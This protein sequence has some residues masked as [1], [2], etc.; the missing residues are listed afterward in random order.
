VAHPW[1]FA[2]DRGAWSEIFAD[3][4]II[5]PFP[6]LARDLTGRS[7]VDVASFADAE[8]N[9]RKLFV[10]TA[11]GWR[12]GEHHASV[13]REWPQVV[14]IA[15]SPGYHWQEPDLPQQLTAV[16]GLDGVGPIAFSEVIRDVRYLI[17]L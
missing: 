5:Q 6:Q 8:V 11:R 2:A 15:Y 10:L 4:A 14:E 9:G 12:F 3:Y 17:S 1:H 16:H 13:L 7:E